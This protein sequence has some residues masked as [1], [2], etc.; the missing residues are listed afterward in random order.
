MDLLHSC[1]LGFVPSIAHLTAAEETA[2]PE[3]VMIEKTKIFDHIT[4]CL[5]RNR[6]ASSRCDFVNDSFSCFVEVRHIRY[7]IRYH[8]RFSTASMLSGGSDP[9]PEVSRRPVWYLCFLI[10]F[11]IVLSD[12]HYFP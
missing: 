2:V 1:N 12:E 7:H 5:A 8:I 10:I 3:S 6:L 11:L 9:F 4:A